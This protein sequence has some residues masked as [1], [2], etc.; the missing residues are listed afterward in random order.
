[1]YSF[2][3]LRHLERQLIILLPNSRLWISDAA[4]QHGDTT[5]LLHC[6]AVAYFALWLARRLRLKCD[7]KSLIRGALL[8]DYFLYDWHVPD[9]SHRLHGF[10]HPAIALE[11]AQADLELS[12]TEQDIIL[13]HMFPLTP[14]PPRCREAVLVCMVDKVCGLYETFGRNTYPALRRM[15]RRQSKP[16]SQVHSVGDCIPSTIA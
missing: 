12:N 2:R 11:N 16:F 15:L 6:I 7:E 14:T 1:M 8:H 9:P 5:V 4:I 3:L 10:R 13:H